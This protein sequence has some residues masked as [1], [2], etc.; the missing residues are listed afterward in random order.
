[1]IHRADLAIIQL[2]IAATLLGVGIA[3]FAYTP[4]LPELVVQGWFNDSQAVYLGAA[5]LLGYLLG[6]VSAHPLS[7]RF[8]SPVLLR[9]S[10]AGVVLSFALCILPGWF[11]WFFLWRFVAG[12]T[13]AW[14]MVLAPSAALSLAPVERRGNVGALVFTGIG[15]GAVISSL[16]VPLLINQDLSFTWAV[17]A[18]A[19]LLVAWVG[20]AGLQKIIRQGGFVASAS[21]TTS[22]I[23][24][25]SVT[26]QSQTPPS[27]IKAIVAAVILVIFAYG[28]DAIA[29]VPHSLFWVDY[30]AR[31]QELGVN[32]ASTQWLIFGVGACCGPIMTAWLSQRLGIKNALA[33]AYLAKAL[34]I[35]VMLFS[36]EIFSRSLSS[37]LVGAMV[38]GVV[39]LTSA[40]L[41]HWL[42]AARHKALWGMATAVFALCQAI[43]GYVMSAMYV[44][45][46]SYYPLFFAAAIIMAVG[47][48]LIWIAGNFRRSLQSIV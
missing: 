21:V 42:G 47:F 16:A 15:L 45:L 27:G 4:L 3:R 36:T 34:G 29:Y 32:I 25:P 44:S 30:L 20:H 48:I 10:F 5:N 31:E 37:F 6:A 1:M 13:G 33:I 38:P 46:G 11:S 9:L 19:S 35:A 28:L 18:L 8:G 41:A 26:S 24:T 40:L 12:A 2:G 23:T 7:Q 17:L 39:G 43:S 14:L 22:S